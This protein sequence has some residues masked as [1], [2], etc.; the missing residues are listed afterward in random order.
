MGK[1][2]PSDHE[3]F[4]PIAEEVQ[5]DMK[6]VFF[7]QR[8]PRCRRGDRPAIELHDQ[9]L[10][11]QYF[12]TLQT[13]IQVFVSELPVRISEGPQSSGVS[14]DGAKIR[15]SERQF[16]LQPVGGKLKITCA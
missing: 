14:Q 7:I 3:P 5:Q 15:A 10:G 4:R 8:K 9:G 16:A 6:V 13:S 2:A 12:Q 1:K 11:G